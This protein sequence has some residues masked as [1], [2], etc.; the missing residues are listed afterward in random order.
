MVHLPATHC[1]TAANTVLPDLHGYTIIHGTNSKRPA[2]RNQPNHCQVFTIQ[3]RFTPA[4]LRCRSA[5]ENFILACS[6]S[7][8]RGEPLGCTWHAAGGEGP[9]SLLPAGPVQQGTHCPRSPATG[10]RQYGEI[11]LQWTQIGH[12]RCSATVRTPLRVGE[13]A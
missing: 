10:C 8:G 9:F 11:R 7:R 4:I 5:D 13:A 6:E 3:P 12:S 2:K 1:P